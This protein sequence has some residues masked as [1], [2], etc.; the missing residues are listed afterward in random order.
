MIKFPKLNKLKGFTLI[1]LLTVIAVMGILTA[2]AVPSYAV[3]KQHSVLDSA[4]QEV[5]SALKTAQNMAMTAQ[6]GEDYFNVTFITKNQYKICIGQNS[7][8]TQVY[9]P[10]E[11][12]SGLVF[13]YV[14]PQTSFPFTINFTRLTGNSSAGTVKIG[15]PGKE[16][17]IQVD[18]IGKITIQ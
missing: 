10:P 6:G 12:D 5:V 13:S 16:K 14:F 17:T 8:S 18:S 1:E 4:A 3:I 2:V 11:L 15:L 9:S 7:C